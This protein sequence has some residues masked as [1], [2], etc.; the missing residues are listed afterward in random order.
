MTLVSLLKELK[1]KDVKL[2]L[3]GD[4]I[5]HTVPEGELPLELHAQIAEHEAELVQILSRNQK[6]K[7]IPAISRNEPLH[8]SFVQKGVWYLE[9]L[10][11]LTTSHHM[12][13]V[14]DLIGDFD[15]AAFEDA[16]FKVTERHETLRTAFVTLEN[17][18]LLS[19]QAKANIDFKS[20]DLGDLQGDEQQNWLD[21][22]LK[23]ERLTTFDLSRA[24]LLRVR[25]FHLSA[26]RHVVQFV[27]HHIICDAWS[28]D[29]LL[30]EI[31]AIYSGR[32]KIS[33][34]FADSIC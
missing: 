27:I 8:L 5:Q 17:E 13:V 30:H 20:V 22:L 9:Q 33:Q 2:W 12:E 24:P 7:S 19:I 16:L 11:P 34:T 31:G 4:L 32:R 25:V 10:N 18:P 1:S 3:E 14:R 23:K 6:S 21:H 26:Q 15:Q 28:V 29:L